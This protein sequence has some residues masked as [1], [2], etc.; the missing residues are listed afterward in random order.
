MEEAMTVSR[1]KI[2]ALRE[3]RA[4]SQAHLAEAAGLSLRTIQRVEAEGTASAET[5]LAIA[6]ALNVPV[7]TLSGQESTL[8]SPNPSVPIGGVAMAAP[9]MFAAT[10][11]AILFA[12]WLGRGLP[13]EV[14]SHF[15]VAGNADATMP[16]DAF[17]AV[18]CVLMA[19]VPSVL[20][21][22]MARAATAQRMNIPNASFWFA[23]PR[24]RATEKTLQL[25]CTCFCVGLIAF[26]GYVFWL[27]ASA[28]R[29]SPTHPVLDT[30][31]MLGGLGVFLALTTAWLAALSW[32]FRRVE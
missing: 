12:L 3:A 32:R 14:T 23:E 16:R 31:L 22:L 25:Q 13:A 18:M 1:E 2:R 9:L 24:R 21:T 30:C 11:C 7:E 27:V 5:R 6:A 17:V 10:A 19:G 8:V 29:A 4:W 28:N 15:G 26:L 20:W